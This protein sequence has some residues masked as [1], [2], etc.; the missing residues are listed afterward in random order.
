[1]IKLTLDDIVEAQKTLEGKVKRTPLNPSTTFSKMT[2]CEVY[3][4]HENLQK[5]GSFKVRGAY[6]KIANLERDERKRGI[7][8]VSTGN[9]A[10]GVA[11]AATIFGTPS[12]IVM[13]KGAPIS[14][15]EATK[16]YGGQVILWGDSFEEAFTKA[17]EIKEKDNLTL[18]HAFDDVDVAAGQGTI[19]L[20]ILEDLPEVDLVVCP[21]G[22]GGLISGI[23]T[24]IKAK[25]PECRIIGVQA[26][27]MDAA[28]RSFQKGTLIH[29]E[30]GNT[31]ADGI[32]IK[33]PSK[34]TFS[35]IKS[36]LDGIVIVEE[37]EIAQ[38]MLLLLERCKSV[39]E[40]A[41][42]VALA[43]LLYQNIAKKGEKVVLVVSG[44]NVDTTILSKLITQGLIK[45]GRY[46]ELRVLMED[47]PG[48][49]ETLLEIISDLEA[50]I[51]DINV[52]R[53]SPDLP[54]NHVI[55]QLAVETKNL[56][57]SVA[58]LKGIKKQFQIQS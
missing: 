35:I 56:D 18:I 9:H 45:S 13:P 30:K 21:I 32:A 42:A 31:I 19:G 51:I 52:D 25:K 6:N 26:K 27:K 4:K 40:G 33:S 47:K 50:N 57:H 1:M 58:L 15:V 53:F 22:G 36:L 10:Q 17:K 48:K 29:T 39:V 2:G 16:G 49:L 41:G 24:A 7:V 20:E 14:K 28:Y 37:E 46:R 3:I 54:F 55:V 43:A 38:A 34:F 8:A 23:S 5:A 11:L 44:G 12:T